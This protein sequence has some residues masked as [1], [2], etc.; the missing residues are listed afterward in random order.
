MT[1]NVFEWCNDNYGDEYYK[2]S[3]PLNPQGPTQFT[4]RKV[5]RGGAWN[6][7]AMW[8]TV[9]ER[10]LEQFN[11]GIGNVGFRVVQDPY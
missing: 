5:I 6:Q 4:G 10:S 1:G 7:Y 2:V 8:M 3:L 11:E 9:A